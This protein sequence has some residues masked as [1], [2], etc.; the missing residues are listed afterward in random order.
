MVDK[1]LEKNVKQPAARPRKRKVRLEW[2]GVVPFLTFALLFLILPS[3]N[4]LIGSFQDETGNFTLAN[5]GNLFQPF[6]LN[7]YWL[8]IQVSAVTALGGVIFGFGLAYASIRGGLP[9]WVRGALMTFSGV[10]SNFAG[11]PLAFAFIATLGR[12]GFITVLLK[13][14][15]GVNLYDTGFSL[16]TF[17][18]LSLTYMYFQFPLMVLI[19]A[20]AIDG[21]KSQWREAAENLGATSFQYW[22]YVALPILGPALLGA[23]VL[24]FGNAFGAYATAFALTGGTLNLVPIQIGAQIRG[25]VLHN[26][27]LG[28]ALAMGMVVI[29]AVSIGISMLL[30]RRTARW[31][32]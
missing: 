14:M 9:S 20:P 13:N 32:Q 28:Y 25:D 24:L 18:G 8:S 16:Y 5:I 12:T 6:I 1:V 2:L 7:S 23:G 10:A 30:Q 3:F 21:L 19:I 26:P 27:N 17:W 4:L 15:L 31:I 11:I 22:R 29:M